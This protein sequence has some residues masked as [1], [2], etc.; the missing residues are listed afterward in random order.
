MK[1]RATISEL[2]Y[3][4]TSTQTMISNIHR[5]MM[6]SQEGTDDQRQLVSSTRTLPSTEYGL[7]ATQT[8]TR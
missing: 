2:E 4:V 1:T 7:P 8:Q 5:T 6:K 3:N